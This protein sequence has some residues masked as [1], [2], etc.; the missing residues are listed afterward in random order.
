MERARRSKKVAEHLAGLETRRL[1][2]MRLLEEGWHQAEVAR[3]LG[4]KPCSVSRWRKAHREG[5][6]DALKSPGR[7]GRKPK[8][9]EE[10]WE[11]VEEKLVAG[12]LS[13]GY[14][15]ELWTLERI[16]DVVEGI[17][18]HRYDIGQ[19]SRLMRRHGWS[20]QKPK[21]KAKERDEE[22]IERWVKEDWPRIKGGQNNRTPS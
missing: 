5:G 2:A 12:P 6:D 16:R 1:E 19:L 8:L 18:G 3:R 17:S 11:A 14:Q 10:Q 9:S 15:T 7:S 21:R 13:S 22:A 20:C 4:V